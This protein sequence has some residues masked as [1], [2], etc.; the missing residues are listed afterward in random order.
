MSLINKSIINCEAFPCFTP[1]VIDSFIVLY[2]AS[3]I[4]RE[5]FSI[6]FEILTLKEILF[7]ID[8]LDKCY[9]FGYDTV[10]KNIDKIFTKW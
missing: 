10:V 7:D 1:L 6:S 4:K 2:N 9:K 5:T 8:K 3:L